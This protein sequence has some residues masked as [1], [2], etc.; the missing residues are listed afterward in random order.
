MPETATTTKR[1][2]EGVA[3][4]AVKLIPHCRGLDWHANECKR[5]K[6]DQRILQACVWGVMGKPIA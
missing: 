1:D 4:E 3:G 6:E 2:H 5:D